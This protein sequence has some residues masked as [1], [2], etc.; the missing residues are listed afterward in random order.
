[1][2]Q[3]WLVNSVTGVIQGSGFVSGNYDVNSITA[4]NSVA[5]EIPPSNDLQLWKQGQ[6]VDRPSKPDD[7]HLWIDGAWQ[8]DESSVAATIRR[9]RDTFLAKSDWTQMPDVTLANKPAWTT[10]RQALRGI[11]AQTGYPFNI[12]WPTPPQ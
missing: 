11:T 10:Y 5:V 6:W 2:K 1:M 7:N 4:E 9:Q 12:V 3:I 8:L